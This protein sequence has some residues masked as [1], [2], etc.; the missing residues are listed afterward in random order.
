[1]PFKRGFT[2]IELLVVISI[3][4][5]LIAILLPAL[6]KVRESA[7]I[8][9]CTTNVRSFSQAM[10]AYQADTG[11]MPQAADRWHDS[12][13]RHSGYNWYQTLMG[14]GEDGASTAG[15]MGDNVK[16]EVQRCPITMNLLP[17]FVVND[18]GHSD[19]DDNAVFTYKYNEKIGGLR[20]SMVGTG[21]SVDVTLRPYS[22]DD[23]RETASTVLIAES[24]QPW[25]YNTTAFSSN[26]LRNR[27]ALFTTPSDASVAHPQ[28][29]IAGAITVGS[30]T[31]PARTGT[32]TIAW[33]D[34]SAGQ[35]RGRQ[36]NR[37]MSQDQSDPNNSFERGNT[38][39]DD[40][41]F[42][43]FWQR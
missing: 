19:S 26:F 41:V 32:G 23:I 8:M 37:S 20:E 43:P 7:N 9:V 6:A 39:P 15:Y 38:D 2:L 3:I 36:N 11:A 34:G 10:F 18:S 42:E 31:L 5:L 22:T 1:M 30:V 40:M 21:S 14:T 13:G 16:I 25:S 33:A 28:G 29:E 27:V 24:V 4:A 35:E 17:G 12:S